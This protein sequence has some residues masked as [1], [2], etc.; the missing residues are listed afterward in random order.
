[1]KKKDEPLFSLA[2]IHRQY[3]ACRSHKRNTANALRFEAA[4]E[5]SLRRCATPWSRSQ[6]RAR[7]FCLFFY[8]TPETA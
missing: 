3:V 2:N 5:L 7:S 1:M 6:L 4:Q 8:P